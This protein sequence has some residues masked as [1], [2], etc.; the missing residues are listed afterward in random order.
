MEKAVQAFTKKAIQTGLTLDATLK[1]FGFTWD[2]L[3]EWWKN[4]QD[5]YIQTIKIPTKPCPECGHTMRLY[6]LN[7]RPDEMVEGFGSMWLC[8]TSCSGRGCGYDEYSIKTFEEEL[9]ETQ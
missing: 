4:R 1:Q 3:R 7:T 8:G 5:P 6:T 2:D 9:K